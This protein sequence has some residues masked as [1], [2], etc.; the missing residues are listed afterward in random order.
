MSRKKVIF[1]ESFISDLMKYTPGPAIVVNE[2]PRRRER[3]I[4]NYTKMK[5]FSS[6]IMTNPDQIAPFIE[7]VLQSASTTEG[8]NRSRNIEIM[9]VRYIEC[10]TLS[11]TGRLFGLT[12][13]RVA[14]IAEEFFHYARWRVYNGF[15]AYTDVHTLPIPL[16]RTHP[17]KLNKSTILLID[18]IGRWNDLVDFLEMYPESIPGIVRNV[19]AMYP[20][21][22]KQ[23]NIDIIDALFV[24]GMSRAQTCRTLGVS[25]TTVRICVYYFSKLVTH[26]MK[27]EMSRIEEKVLPIK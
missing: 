14:S 9:K 3:L 23:E 26:F 11:E 4:R 21:F 8:Y 20:M 25:E 7:R 13:S 24:K 15:M 10:K 5:E 18:S 17:E 2:E 22:F 19:I 6:F 12:G 16:N 1:P 27:R